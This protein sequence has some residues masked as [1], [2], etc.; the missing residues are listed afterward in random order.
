VEKWKK[1]ISD[2]IGEVGVTRSKKR[3]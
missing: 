2:I 3:I 1:K